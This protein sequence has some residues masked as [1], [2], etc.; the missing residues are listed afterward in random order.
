MGLSFPSYKVSLDVV[1]RVCVCGERDCFAVDLLT[2]ASLQLWERQIGVIPE[3]A[4][5]VWACPPCARVPPPPRGFQLAGAQRPAGPSFPGGIP[6]GA[7][8]HWGAGQGGAGLP[9][10]RRG[11]PLVCAVGTMAPASLLT[12]LLLLFGGFPAASA[13]SV[14]V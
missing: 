11:A 12:L 1:P 5:A 3:Q 8:G 13:E 4:G 14:G 7:S 9:P 2:I 10:I 6:G